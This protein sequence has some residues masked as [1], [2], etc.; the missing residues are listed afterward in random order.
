V[1]RFLLPR[2]VQ[3]FL[4][5]LAQ[6]LGGAVLLDPA[7]ELIWQAG[8]HERATL[9]MPVVC[10]AYTGIL[11][12]PPEQ[13]EIGALA[14]SALERMAT[15]RATIDDLASKTRRLWWEQNLL[16][17]AGEL[18]RHGFADSDIARWLVERLAVMEPQT[19]VVLNW[20]GKSLEVADG[21]LPEGLRVGDKLAVSALAAQVLD[22]GEALAFA[23]TAEEPVESE[24]LVPVEPNQPCLLV[25]LRSADRVLGVVMVLRR[26]GE[27]MFTA[28][29]LKL[30]QLL[31]DLASVALT[32]RILI[33]EAEHTA[34]VVRELELAAEI[35]RR[36]FPPPL[37][38]YGSLEVAAR[39]EPVTQVGG[40]GFLQRRLRHGGVALG[41]VDLTGHGIGVSLALSALFAR[42]DALADAVETPGQ[43]LSIVNDQLT[44]GE[45]N[46]FTMATAVVAFVDPETGRFSLSTAAHPRALIRRANGSFEV[47]EKGGLPLGVQPGEE[48]PVEDGSLAPGDALVLYS[49][50]I[51]E[52][53]GEGDQ[54]F[55]VEGL[56]RALAGGA[57]SAAEVV[58][59]VSREVSVFSRK[60]SPIDDRTIMVVRRAEEHRG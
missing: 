28:E 53:I 17:Y 9:E 56:C 34:R 27:P 2:D 31:S 19:V 43:L 58:A 41:V 55:G 32:N 38:R 14:V 47:M 12:I 36:L 26:V 11:A 39:C 45:F 40:D 30:V 18:L 6:A 50:G 10:G 15:A 35:Q 49:D 60:A 37:A 44:S 33:Q 48:Y 51:S 7:G 4:D 3:P 29:Q 54:T 20:D 24:L 23:T 5:V 42:L 25:P 59:A 13:A 8:R 46:T 22:R 52:T 16:F 21:K 57:A 1:T